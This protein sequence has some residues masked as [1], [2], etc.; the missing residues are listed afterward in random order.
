MFNTVRETTTNDA[1]LI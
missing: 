1:I